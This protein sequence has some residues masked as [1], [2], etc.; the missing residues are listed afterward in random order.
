MLL[1]KMDRGG[2]RAGL[3]CFGGGSG[4]AGA[5]G[6]SVVLRSDFPHAI[7]KDAISQEKQGF[8]WHPRA[9]P[10][11]QRPHQPFQSTSPLAAG[12][13]PAPG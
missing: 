11:G 3:G 8:F 5:V 1:L 2:W 7:H 10:T 6:F 13:A 4:A 12:S 9:S